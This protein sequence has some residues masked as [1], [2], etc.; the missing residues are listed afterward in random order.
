MPKDSKGYMDYKRLKSRDD[1]Y[2]MQGTEPHDRRFE[3]FN[4]FPSVS[5]KAQ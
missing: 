5:T 1:F 3:L 4:Y 2:K